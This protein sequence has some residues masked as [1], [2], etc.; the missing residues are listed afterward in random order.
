MCTTE[1][2]SGPTELRHDLHFGL[3]W[4]VCIGCDWREELPHLD[5]QK[6]RFLARLEGRK[7]DGRAMK[8]SA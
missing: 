6:G 7:H 1:Q 3:V 4:C 8:P 5:D 2:C